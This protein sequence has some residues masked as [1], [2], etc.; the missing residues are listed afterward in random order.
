MARKLL[1]DSH[2]RDHE[3]TA[4]LA[5]DADGKF[6]ALRVS[7]SSA[8]AKASPDSDL[9]AGSSTQRAA[10]TTSR[11]RVEAIKTWVSSSSG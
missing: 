8:F 4:E 11:G 3:M 6:L 10:V 9:F 1:S 7:R 2:G 5:L